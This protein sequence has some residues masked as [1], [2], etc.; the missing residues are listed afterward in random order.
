MFRNY[1]RY[2]EG[3]EKEEDAHQLNLTFPTNKTE[4]SS[5]VTTQSH[6]LRKWILLGVSI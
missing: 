2:Q 1:V 4:Q 3:Q 5:M 6:L